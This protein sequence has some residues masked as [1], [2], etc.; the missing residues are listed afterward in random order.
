MRDDDKHHRWH[1]TKK[2]RLYITW[3]EDYW[4]SCPVLGWDGKPTGL[5]YSCLKKRWVGASRTDYPRRR[6]A[7]IMKMI[8]INSAS[9]LLPVICGMGLGQ[10]GSVNLCALPPSQVISTPMP[11]TKFPQPY[12]YYDFYM[13][14]GFTKYYWKF[15]TYNG[16][17]W[18]GYTGYQSFTRSF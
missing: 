15:K 6:E 10:S 11:G 13:P 16:T 3:Q 5:Y 7:D 9:F 8:T 12:E 18:S 1:P 2:Y 4:S 14:K 17:M